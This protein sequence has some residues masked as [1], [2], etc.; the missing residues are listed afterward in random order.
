MLIL[1][2]NIDCYYLNKLTRDCLDKYHE[3]YG[4]GESWSTKCENL[5]KIMCLSVVTSLNPLN[6]SSAT[7]LAII[8]KKIFLGRSLGAQE[9]VALLKM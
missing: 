5:V 7:W 2:V 4:R 8:L 9:L 1:I 6:I 3:I